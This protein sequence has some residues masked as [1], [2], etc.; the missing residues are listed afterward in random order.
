MEETEKVKTEEVASKE[1]ATGFAL[2]GNMVKNLQDKHF[3]VCGHRTDEFKDFKDPTKTV[4]RI[5][6]MIK[7]LDGT[8]VDYFPNKSSQKVLIAKRGFKYADWVG[9]EGEFE[10]LSQRI[11]DVTKEVIYIKK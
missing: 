6:L 5:V 1:F 9:F 11:N 3:L 2:D 10:T 4:S 7:L 8:I